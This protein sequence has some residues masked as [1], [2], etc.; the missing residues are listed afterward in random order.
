MFKPKIFKERIYQEIATQKFYYSLE[1]KRIEKTKRQA[2]LII[3]HLDILLGPCNFKA[4][5][6]VKNEANC[7]RLAQQVQMSI[8]KIMLNTN[9]EAQLSEETSNIRK[10]QS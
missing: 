1:L 8:C 4:D 9:A 5:S 10:Y 2:R 6:N 3:V 7:K